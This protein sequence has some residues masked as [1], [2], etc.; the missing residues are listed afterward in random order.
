MLRGLRRREEVQSRTVC[1][2]FPFEE[3]K[4][5]AWREWWGLEGKKWVG[6]EDVKAEFGRRKESNEA[7]LLSVIALTLPFSVCLSPW[8]VHLSVCQKLDYSPKP[9]VKPLSHVPTGLILSLMSLSMSGLLG[10]LYALSGFHFLTGAWAL[11][12]CQPAY[13]NFPF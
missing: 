7:V 5:W 9:G 13:P 12:W 2:D 3:T 1:Q 4:G 8:S 10:W 6:E 11:P